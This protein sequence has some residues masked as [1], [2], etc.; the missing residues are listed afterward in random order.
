MSMTGWTD[1]EKLLGAWLV[2]V[3]RQP[4]IAGCLGNPCT[5]KAEYCSCAMQLARS[6]LSAL[7][8]PSAARDKALEAKFDDLCDHAEQLAFIATQMLRA[9]GDRDHMN[10]SN[11][12]VEQ[13]VAIAKFCRGLAIKMGWDEVTCAR[14]KSSPPAPDG[15]PFDSHLEPHRPSP[16]VAIGNA[17]MIGASGRNGDYMEWPPERTAI[18]AMKE[19]MKVATDLSIAQTALDEASAVNERTQAEL[20]AMRKVVE[21]AEADDMPK[22]HFEGVNVSKEWWMNLQ[23]A[24]DALAALTPRKEKDNG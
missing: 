21:A 7:P 23:A 17:A 6:A 15:A 18:E 24:L 8:S 3:L 4:K 2:R 19:S 10:A 1:E 13:T 11:L 22:R 9:D 16:E 5:G 12:K 20:A 14:L